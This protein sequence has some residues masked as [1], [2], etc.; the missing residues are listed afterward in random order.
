MANLRRMREWHFNQA[1]RAKLDGKEQEAD[2]HLLYYDLLGCAVE[3][4]RRPD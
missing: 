3:C 2:F 4:E 1:M